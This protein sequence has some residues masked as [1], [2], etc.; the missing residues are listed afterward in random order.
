MTQ[1]TATRAKLLEPALS[2]FNCPLRGQELG[3]NRSQ[4]NHDGKVVQHHWKA[5]QDC[6]DAV[7]TQAQ[8]GEGTAPHRGGG[9]MNSRIARIVDLLAE[10]YGQEYDRPDPLAWGEF[11]LGLRHGILR[12]E[13]MTTFNPDSPYYR[14][15]DIGLQH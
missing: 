5:T 10:K 6:L 15:Y 3:R 9:R 2:C 11:E 4:C 1:L 12:Q 7:E 8:E 13:K 14:G